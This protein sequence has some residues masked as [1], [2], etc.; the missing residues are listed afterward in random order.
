MADQTDPNIRIHERLDELNATQ[1]TILVNLAEIRGAT[2][3]H[4]DDM[5]YM[6]EEFAK[7][8]VRAQVLR[9]WGTGEI[10]RI[11]REVASNK[12]KVEKDRSYLSGMLAILTA[13]VA[14]FGGYFWTIVDK[15]VDKLEMIEVVSYNVKD[16]KTRQENTD[17]KVQFLQGLLIKK[18]GEK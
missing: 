4:A 7:R 1:T 14:I 11:D 6:R 3:Q 8:D 15:M 12:L 9:D 18:E 5:E 10:T 2:K 17:S 16:L 13:L